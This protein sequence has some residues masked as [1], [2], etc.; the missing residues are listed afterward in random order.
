MKCNAPAYEGIEPYIFISYCH[1]DQARVYPYI[2]MLARDGYRLWYDEG[3][4]PGD[5][6]TENIGLHLENCSVFI[7]FVTEASMNSHNCRREINFAVQRN[8]KFISLFLDDVRMSPGMELMLSNV[9]G[10]YRSN[11]V[12][13]EDFIR[14]LCASEF[15]D[16]CK[17]QVRPEVLVMD[18][19]DDDDRTLTLTQG[20][21]DFPGSP[22]ET[23]LMRIRTKERIYIRKSLF[24]IGRSESHSDYVIAGEP[25]ISR[26][27][28]TIRKYRDSYTLIDNN[29]LN[30]VAIN[31]RLIAPSIE[32]EMSAYDV[33][34]LAKENL[35][36]FKNYRED[37]LQML[38][39]MELR[40]ALGTWPIEKSPVIRIGSQPP[41]MDGSGNE[42]CIRAPGVEP[43]HACLIYGQEQLSIVDVCGTGTTMVNQMTVPYGVRQEL[44]A[45][46]VIRIG[47][48]SFEVFRR[49]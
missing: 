5:E 28:A 8:L 32:Y 7:A 10:I 35:V 16:V 30:H 18:R 44:M 43:L 14:K 40:G 13:A 37:L 20:T 11:Y 41:G 1:E 15:L 2:E 24:T 39:G 17:G 42:I 25:S 47:D 19:I 4:T 6:W 26:R 9:Q 21:A 27:H 23:Y 45:G 31:G 12:L 33:I 48:A 36:F 49:I 29:S 3:I 46:D 34:S 38:P 22:G